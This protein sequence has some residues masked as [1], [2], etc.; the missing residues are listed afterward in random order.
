MNHLA[1]QYGKVFGDVTGVQ[2]SGPKHVLKQKF[3]VIHLL[4][5]CQSVCD[6]DKCLNLSKTKFSEPA[7]HWDYNAELRI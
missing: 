5:V 2:I 1:Q 3:K 4:N 6:N 7:P